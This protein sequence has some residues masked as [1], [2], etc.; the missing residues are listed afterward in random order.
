MNWLDIV[1]ALIV[2][3]PTYFGFRKGFLRKLL[4]IAGIIV[5]FVIAVKFYDSVSNI[6]SSV[7]KENKTFVDV[8]SFLLIIGVLYGASVWLARFI[9]NTN[10]GTGVVDKVLGMIT[11]FAQGL[12]LASVL[13]YN[14]S[15][16]DM[17][18][19]Q[20][21]ESSMLYSRVYNIA[22][23][24]FDK[25]IELFP[26]LQDIYKEYKNPFTNQTEPQKSK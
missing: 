10:S 9:A 6:L 4:G 7:I 24:L 8:I 26:G 20:T 21:R 19:K 22:P 14:L 11:G 18:S 25:V 3:L 23:A 2:T 16:A 17:P 13:L 12:I 1:I 15:L 5:G